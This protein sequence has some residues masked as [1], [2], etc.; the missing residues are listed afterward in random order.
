MSLLHFGQRALHRISVGKDTVFSFKK[1]NILSPF[2]QSSYQHLF[3]P[4]F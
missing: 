3:S 2:S 4:E 1:A